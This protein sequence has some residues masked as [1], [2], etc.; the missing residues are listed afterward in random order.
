MAIIDDIYANVDDF[1]LITSAKAKELGISNSEM[2]QQERRGK[3]IRVARGVYR[4]PVWP[5][6]EAAPY[7][8]A[9]RAAG[10]NAYLWG[11]SV[12]ALLGLAPTDPTHIWVAS[13]DRIRRS[14][15]GGVTVLDMRGDE[16]TAHYEGI[17]CQRAADAIAA[18]ILRIG[19]ERALNAADAALREGYITKAERDRLEDT[20]S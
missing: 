19:R 3:L 14:V 1:G 15:G 18:S 8:I 4:M 13:P 11:E 10:K 6:Q 12:I 2:V 5:Y 9:V 17:R 16:P 7:A 20:L